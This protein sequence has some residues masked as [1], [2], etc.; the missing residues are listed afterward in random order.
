M[1]TNYKDIMLQ[2][3]DGQ[4]NKQLLNL[5]FSDITT[6][7]T[8]TLAYWIC[9]FKGRGHSFIKTPKKVYQAIYNGSPVC[10]VCKELPYERSIEYN[11][12]HQV[13][14]YWDYKKNAEMNI[15]PQY[16]PAKSNEMIFVICEEHSW[17]D[18]QRCA[19][20]ADHDS[21]PFCNGKGATPKYNLQTEFPEI[22]ETLH[23]DFDSTL[24]LP[25]SSKLYP[26]WCDECQE[27]YDKPVSSRTEQNQG[28]PNH[29][30]TSTTEQL[31]TMVLNEL[32]GGFTKYKLDSIRWISNGLAVE[33]DIYNKIYGIA[34]EYDGIQHGKKKRKLSD[35]KKNK[36]L[37]DCP[38]VTTFIRIRDENL[39]KLIYYKNQYEIVCKSHEYSYSFIVPAVQKIL[40]ILNH[41]FH[42]S[43]LPI[44]DKSLYSLIRK[45][46]PKIVRSNISNK[47]NTIEAKA[48][49]LLRY[50]AE[51]QNHLTCGSHEILD[52]ISCPHCR[53][54]YPPKIVKNFIKSKG[55]CPKCL[56]FVKDITDPNSPLERW[57]PK[58]NRL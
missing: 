33:I 38:E 49:G 27:F 15:Y 37:A 52:N 50:I 17:E 6:K 55:L 8:E 53:K 26:W 31:L 35:Q 10:T 4:K 1:K 58:F 3:W 54:K 47:A 21:C 39:P 51:S 20:L 23:P 36:M 28:C 32:I 7:D 41:V 29:V 18:M 56:H 5:E 12:P 48:P 14:K 44:S 45:C 46:L 22:A 11:A 40:I 19:D 43:L 13:K 25:Y 34:I 30:V 57:H 24:I 42:L 9:T 2:M 16:T